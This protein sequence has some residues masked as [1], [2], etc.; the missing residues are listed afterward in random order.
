[1]NLKILLASSSALIIGLSGVA[2]ADSIN[3]GQ[4]G[5]NG[6]TFPNVLTGTTTDGV[7]ITVTGPGLGF[8]VLEEGAGWDGNFPANTPVLF[9]NYAP[10]A[11][12]IDFATPISNITDLA[13]ELN[14]FGSFTATLQAYDGTTLLGSQSFT[15]TSGYDPGTQMSFNFSGSGITSIVLSST[16]DAEGL[17][18]GGA[19]GTGGYAGTPEPSTWFLMIGG[20][21]GIGLM[22]RR[23]KRQGVVVI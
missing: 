13:L 1:M 23:A 18:L 5:P 11:V 14:L 19:G 15:S 6:S 9:D 10:G 2:H 20:L 21:A 8:E 22:L 7:G 3:F 4:F 17:G 16:N 12:T